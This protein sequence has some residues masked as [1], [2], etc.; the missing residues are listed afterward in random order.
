MAKLNETHKQSEVGLTLVGVLVATLVF[1][2]ILIATMNL[3]SRTTREV[4]RG[5]EQFIATNLAREGLELVQF[6]RDS[7]F[8]APATPGT[9]TWTDLSNPAGMPALCAGDTPHA[10]TI[11]PD[12]VTSPPLPLNVIIRDGSAMEPRLFLDAGRYN[13]SGAGQ[14]TEYSRDITIE[15]DQR[16]AVTAGSENEHI[17][18]TS[19]V[20]WQSRGEN[21]DVTLQTHLYNWYQ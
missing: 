15:C 16:N 9:N 18:V 19:R 11:E 7:N 17:K 13:H 1:V 6:V 20:T 10:F 2:I 14:L 12:F 5:R 4:G 3:L 8:F 21:H